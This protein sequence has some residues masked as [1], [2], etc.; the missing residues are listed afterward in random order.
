MNASRTQVPHNQ[1]NTTQILPLE[2]GDRLS[3]VEFERRYTA[4]PKVKK[5]ELIEGVVYMASPVRH[6]SHGKPHAVIMTWLSA[7]WMATP[8]VDF[9]DNATVRLDPDN[10]P[11]PDALLR[12]E[13]GG[14]SFVSDDDYIEGAPELIVEIAASSASYD[15]YDKKRVYRRNGVQEYIVW[16]TF[17]NKLDWFILQAGEYVL[18]Q[19]DNNV[20]RSLVFPGLWLDIAALLAGDIAKAIAV[21]QLGLASPEHAQFIELLSKQQP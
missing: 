9:S 6:K 1:Q 21:L 2:N 17:E 16:Q 10:E 15:L 8:G 12:I 5:A 7:Y 13:S 11:Q 19:P 18:L 3:Q 20:V 4:M 14:Q